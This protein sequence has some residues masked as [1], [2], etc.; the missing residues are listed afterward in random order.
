MHSRREEAFLTSDEKKPTSGFE[1]PHPSGLVGPASERNVEIFSEHQ[2][3]ARW[4]CAQYFQPIKCS[5]R[6]LLRHQVLQV[7]DLQVTH[8]QV[9]H[10]ST[11]F[12]FKLASYFQVLLFC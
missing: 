8:M 12:Y 3:Q 10:Q 4:H 11:Y 2:E 9:R 7:L 5:L 1:V 6:S